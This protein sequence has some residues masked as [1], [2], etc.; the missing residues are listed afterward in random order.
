[1]R[2]SYDN[3]S[4]NPRNPTRPPKRVTWGPNTNEEMGDL[5]LQVVPRTRSDLAVLRNDVA[6]KMRRDDLAA[7]DKLL[8]DDPSNP[9][10]HDA[11]ALLQLQGGQFDDAIQHY[12]ASLDL[13][14]ASAPAHYNLAEALLARGRLDDALAE[15]FEALRLN[16]DYAEAHNNAGAVLLSAGREAEAFQHF[17][18][19]LALNPEDADVHNNLARALMR[20]GDVADSLEHFREALNLR[21]DWPPALTGIAWIEATSA[22][23]VFL[24]A[25]EAVRLAERAQMLTAGTDPLVLDALAA[26]YAASGSFDRAIVSARTGVEM[27]KA[28]TPTLAAEIQ[29][30]LELYERHLVYRAPQ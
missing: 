27:A 16:P 28:R 30:R 1:M 8:R 25:T 20:K 9:L 6:Q 21:P 23:P 7:A 19:A 22:E 2:Y 15:F 17:R 5:W 24:N 14:S 18:R 29:R 3:S 12:R 4:Q 13:N 26:A 11:V 10:R